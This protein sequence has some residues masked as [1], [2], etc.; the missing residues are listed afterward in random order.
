MAK[1]ALVLA[2]VA[3]MFISCLAEATN[4]N[5]NVVIEVISDGEH[6]QVIEYS[7]DVSP[8][9]MMKLDQGAVKACSGEICT[10][11]TPCKPP[12]LCL[13]SPLAGICV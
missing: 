10:A 5:Q 2:L 4:N 7:N 13:P 8:R 11:F 3:M 1:M 6:Q 9:K 12:C